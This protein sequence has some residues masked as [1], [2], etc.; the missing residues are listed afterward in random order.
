[1]SLGKAAVYKHIPVYYPDHVGSVGG[2][3]GMIGGLGGFI[4]PIVF[5]ALNDLTG[6]W[7]S[8]FMLLFLLV[9]TALVW[10]HFAVR[11]MERRRAPI[12]ADLP[13][14][15]E[16]AGVGPDKAASSSLRSH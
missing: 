6:V 2:L 16:L 7:T 9:L 15:P 11:R 5:G 8:C 1:M 3:V 14:F 12:L 10:M 4:M 13:E